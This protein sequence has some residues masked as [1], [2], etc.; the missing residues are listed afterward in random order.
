MK[1][2]EAYYVTVVS[3]FA[4]EKLQPLVRKMDKESEM[5]RSIIDGLFENGVS[6]I[7]L[8]RNETS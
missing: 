2:L 8:L 7:C 4:R 1:C 5:D 6:K 3:K